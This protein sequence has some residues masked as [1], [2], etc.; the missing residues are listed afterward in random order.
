MNFPERRVWVPRPMGP[1]SGTDGSRDPKGSCGWSRDPREGASGGLLLGNNWS[2][3]QKS[4]NDLDHLRVLK[5]I[6]IGRWI[7]YD[8]FSSQVILVRS[9]GFGPSTFFQRIIDSFGM[10]QL[11]FFS[12]GTWEYHGKPGNIMEYLRSFSSIRRNARAIVRTSVLHWIATRVYYI[13]NLPG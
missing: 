3:H 4:T 11:T 2:K 8:F 7:S 10:F 9:P 6:D 5:G 12:A 1:N 13:T